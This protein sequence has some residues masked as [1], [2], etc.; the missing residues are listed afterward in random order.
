MKNGEQKGDLLSRELIEKRILG[1]MEGFFITML[2][3]ATKTISS[4]SYAIAK[5][6]GS[7]EDVKKMTF[8]RIS[9]FV[10]PV[11]KKIQLG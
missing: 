11:K 9:S 6:G 8:D 1:P 7:L 5:S 3:D 4:R 10:R 2:T